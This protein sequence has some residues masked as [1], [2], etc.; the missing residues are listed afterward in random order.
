MSLKHD[1]SWLNSTVDLNENENDKEAVIYN[2][3]KKVLIQCAED[4]RGSQIGIFN[5]LSKKFEYK[6]DVGFPDIQ[7]SAYR[8]K[9]KK[10]PLLPTTIEDVIQAMEEWKDSDLLRYHQKT[11]T[12]SPKSEE[13]CSIIFGN[14]YLIE[15]LKSVLKW[16]R[17]ELSKQLLSPSNKFMC[18]CSKLETSTSQHL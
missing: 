3:K 1:R 8:Q 15:H 10:W 14:P 5:E 6:E 7:S 4:P 16:A 17:M 12:Y 9:R 18:I 2:F 11:V 13:V